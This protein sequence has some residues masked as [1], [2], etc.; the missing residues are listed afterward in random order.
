MINLGYALSNP[1]CKRSWSFNSVWTCLFG[2]P[3]SNM[4]H[5][6]FSNIVF[7]VLAC[8]FVFIIHRSNTKLTD[9]NVGTMFGTINVKTVQEINLIDLSFLPAAKRAGQREQFVSHRLSVRPHLSLRI[10][11]INQQPITEVKQRWARLVVGWETT[12]LLKLSNIKPG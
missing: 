7:V 3:D 5:T 9:G 11:S 1:K 8:Y 12:Q 10:C 6:S 2:H 4:E